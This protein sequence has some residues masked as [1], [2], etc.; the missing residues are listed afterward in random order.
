[1]VDR[2]GGWM[3]AQEGISTLDLY[4]TKPSMSVRSTLRVDE[5]SAGP[6]SSEH[7]AASRRRRLGGRP[8]SRRRRVY[9][10]CLPTPRARAKGRAGS[11]PAP[12]HAPGQ[13]HGAQSEKAEE[14]ITASSLSSCGRRR[15]LRRPL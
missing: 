8:Q 10:V 3:C 1:M 11:R 15:R 6:G 4:T 2:C 7:F 5:P 9:T 12:W 14:P 13:R